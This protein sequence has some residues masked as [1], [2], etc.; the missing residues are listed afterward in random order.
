[1]S[2]LWDRQLYVF[3]LDLIGYKTHVYVHIYSDKQTYNG[4]VTT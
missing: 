4:H 1:M 2:D 3:L